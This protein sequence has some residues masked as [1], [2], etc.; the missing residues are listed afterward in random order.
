MRKKLLRMA[1]MFS[2][3]GILTMNVFATTYY[4]VPSSHW[5]Y[6]SIQYMNEN[7]YMV[8]TSSGAFL[9]ELEISY[10][11]MCEILAK[12]TGYK[13]VNIQTD[14]D[15]E[16]KQ[17]L[18]ENYIIQLPVIESYK[19]K[20]QAWSSLADEEIAYLLGRGFIHASELDNFISIN[21]DGNEV[22][23]AVTKEDL[24]VILVR[25][26]QKEQTAQST[27]QEGTF[28]D[29]HL[30]DEYKRPH[31]AYLNSLG[32]LSADESGRFY[33]ETQIT[34]AMMAK[35]TT[36]IIKASNSST[37]IPPTNSE[38]V[39]SKEQV[40]LSKIIDKSSTEKYLLVQFQDGRTNFY[41]YVSGMDI[42]TSAG[43]VI[44]IDDVAIGSELLISVEFVLDTEYISSIQLVGE[45]NSFEEG[46]F[47]PVQ[48]PQP[49]PDSSYDDYVHDI[50]RYTGS[51]ILVGKT[52]YLTIETSDETLTYL[53]EDETEIYFDDG[54][55][56]LDDIMAG[57][58]VHLYVQGNVILEVEV[59][60]ELGN[61]VDDYV[62]S[63][64]T[65][66]I[67]GAIIR[68]V[69]ER[70]DFYE[71]TILLDDKSYTFEIELDASITKNG[72]ESSFSELKAGDSATLFFS[73]D[74]VNGIE[75]E[76]ETQEIEGIIQ[77]IYMKTEPEITILTS[78]GPQTFY[79]NTN[80]T[81]YDTTKKSK[82]TIED[83]ELYTVVRVS[84]ESSEI[85]DLTVEEY[86]KTIRHKGVIKEMESSGKSID[87]LIEYDIMTDQTMFVR[88][89]NVPT[90]TDIIINGQNSYRSKLEVGHEILLTFESYV[91]MI[92]SEIVVLD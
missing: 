24:A 53:I 41:S 20:Y 34:R 55:G 18:R 52:G 81:M 36:D 29:E 25:I 22:R 66:Y 87:V 17:Q 27:Y 45:V 68:S 15:E 65:D 89:I 50:K 12:V 31:A 7:G 92:P 49:V 39:V 44:H 14:I 9:P 73:D 64:R 51:V 58:K 56:E 35:A 86:A 11:D 54:M 2:L 72:Y 85:T 78:D 32:I 26:L 37:V 57:D 70:R 90:S 42:L 19:E 10:F 4:D 1:T 46:F 77:T 5:A 16:F 21:G 75:A 23:N 82:I 3:S 60:R 91:S 76:S 61:A 63:S 33:P 62:N 80:A 67:E 88:T 47:E 79:L 8:G 28:S 6:S 74:V 83:L 59:Y 30:I 84:T 38:S 69:V 43:E 40:T 13:D 48:R 71:V